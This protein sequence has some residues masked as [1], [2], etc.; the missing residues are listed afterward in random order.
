[1]PL[2]QP[3]RRRHLHTRRVECFGYL[4][5]DGLFDIEGH[6]VDTKTYNCDDFGGAVT[7]AGQA[8]HDMWIRVTLDKAYV[9]HDVEAVMDARP[10]GSCPQ[11][12]PD[13]KSLI[14]LKISG[15][16]KRAVKERIG[17]TRGCTHLVELL[18][19]IGTVA[20]QTIGSGEVEPEKPARPKPG[21]RPHFI[22]GCYSW[23]TD[24]PVVRD[25]FPD[26]Y[27]G[28]DLAAGRRAQQ[29]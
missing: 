9:I 20:F 5:D 18:G 15:G 17:G 16:F 27:D 11:V 29:Q 13:M 7:P 2:P 10:Y 24:G 25:R 26:F 23:R 19:P 8:I 12:L 1:M 4:R 3:A 6:I 22:N 21:E 28:P 14:G